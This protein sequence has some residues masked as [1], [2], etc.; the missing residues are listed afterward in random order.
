MHRSMKSSVGVNPQ[1]RSM[2]KVELL[3]NSSHLEPQAVR[4]QHHH[5]DD[6]ME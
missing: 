5:G 2:E 6:D 3:L 1:G 4:L